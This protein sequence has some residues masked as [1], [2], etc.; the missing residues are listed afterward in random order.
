[1]V[2]AAAV[3]AS[4]SPERNFKFPLMRR[5]AAE[6]AEDNTVLLLEALAQPSSICFA[7]FLWVASHCYMIHTKQSDQVLFSTHRIASHHSFFH[8]GRLDG[9]SS[10]WRAGV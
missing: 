9:S 5:P 7:A 1:M 8:C 4:F 3:T 10:G 6:E 2:V